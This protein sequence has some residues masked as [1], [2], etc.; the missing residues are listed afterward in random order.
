MSQIFLLFCHKIK[1]H[2]STIV[3]VYF[4]LKNLLYPN[5]RVYIFISEIQQNRDFSVKKVYMCEIC[6]YISCTSQKKV[7]TLHPISVKKD[8]KTVTIFCHGRA[9]RGM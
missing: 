9:A 2:S 6:V 4:I 5:F 1:L 8:E 3:E 7:V